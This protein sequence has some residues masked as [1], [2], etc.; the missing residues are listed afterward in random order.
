MPNDLYALIAAACWAIG[1]LLSVSPARHLGAFAYTRWRM[2]I[3]AIML[4]FIVLVMNGLQ[5]ISLLQFTTM[6]LSGF[7]G[8]FIGDTALFS[9]MNRLGPR[10]TGMLFATNVLFSVFLGFVFFNERLSVQTTLGSGLIIT[11]VLI[12]IMYG[13][14]KTELHGWES[15]YGHPGIGIALG[16]LA[17]LCH[18]VAIM[19]AKPIMAGNMD[20]AT[21]SAIRVSVS[22]GAHFVL[23]WSGI[24]SVQPKQPITPGV[25][26]QTALSGFVGM[27]LGMTFILLALRLGDLGMVAILSSV[28]PILILPLLW[29]F[30]RRRP[31]P[32][33]WFGALLSVVGTA[34]ILSR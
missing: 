21:A 6:A 20:P 18:S 11:G 7:I 13:Q 2:L 10:R 24:R 26:A 25:L 33:A 34:L 19:I 27:A 1:S 28:T 14:H 4:W 5:S 22:C 23:L 9:A 31:A 29:I 16:L 32:G 8:I 30:L 3:V 15:N 12:A 17:A